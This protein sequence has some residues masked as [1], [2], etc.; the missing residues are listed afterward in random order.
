MIYIA[1]T[2][3]ARHVIKELSVAKVRTVEIRSPNNFFALLDAE[4]GDRIFLT[5]SSAPDIV[6]GTG[7]LIASIRALQTITHR[8]IQSNEDYYEERE[9]Q[10]ARIQLQLLA[11]GRVRRI[12]SIEPGTPLMLDVDEVRYCNAR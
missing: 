8:T 11:I 1:L 6:P 7:G 9:A 4:P 2:G 12:A 5:E 10:A 3:L